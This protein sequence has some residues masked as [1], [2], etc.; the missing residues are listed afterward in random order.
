MMKLIEITGKA[1]AG[2]WGKDDET[3]DGIF[4][5][6][7]TNFTNEGVINYKNVVTRKITKKNIT[8]KY[9][10][11]GDI[12]IE[13]SGGSDKQPVGRVVYFD[14]PDSMFLFNN[15]TGVL[16]IQDKERWEPKYIFYSLFANYLVGG[17]R[18]FENRTTGLHNLQTDKYI[19]QFSIFEK[20][21]GEQRRICELLDKMKKII[22]FKRQQIIELDI[23]VKARFIEMFGG[24]TDKTTLS[25]YI[26]ALIA[27]KSVAGNEECKNKV[28]KTGS[29]SYN[30]FN[31]K[32]VKNLPLDYYPSKEHLVQARDVIISRMNTKELVG[33]AGYVWSVPND[34]YLPD[35]LWKAILMPNCSPIFIWQLLIGKE[36]KMEIQKIASGTSGSMKNISKVRLLEI[37]VV[38]VPLNLQNDFADFVKKIEKTK[39]K[40]QSSLN[41]TQTLFD[42]LMQ[43]YFG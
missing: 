30:Y 34:I 16:R 21:I 35:R 3:G 37:E 22:E 41:E 33:A 2:E 28:L 15:F 19:N 43:K 9:L 25:R 13:K 24:I 42:S 6:R 39:T 36:V 40:I 20:K 18:K 12:I 31:G 27:G 14:G 17:T 10:Q 38:K 1:L 4:V 7:T 29:V 23:L 26:S 32:D 5:L 8:E 11:Y